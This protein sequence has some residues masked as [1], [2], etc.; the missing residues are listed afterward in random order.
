VWSFFWHPKVPGNYYRP[1]FLVWLRL[2][3]V[4][5]RTNPWGWHL[6]TVL[7]HLGAT[8]CVYRLARRVLGDWVAALFAGLI[9]GLHPI[10]IETTAW[11]SG[12]PEPLLVLLVIPAYLCYL[13]TR[14]DRPRSQPWLAASLALYALAMLMKE[15]ALVLP[16]LIFSSRWIGLEAGGLGGIKSWLRR[17]GVS[18]GSTAPYIVLTIPYLIARFFALKG[19]QNPLATLPVIT[20]VSTWPS[21]LWLYLRHLFWPAGL[22]PFYDLTY[23]DHPGFHNVMLPAIPVALAS[24]TLA[25]WATRS[26]RV[27]LASMWLVLPLLPVLNVQVFGN[28]QFA[29]DRYLY[30]PS[31]GFSMLVALALRRLPAG[32]ARLLGQPALQVALILV[33]ACALGL[34]TASQN[35]YY[36]NHTT[37][38]LH[39]SAEAPNNDAIKTNLA[40]LLSEGG[41]YEEAVRIY[42]QVIA[43]N[44]DAGF[45]NYDLGY[46]YYRM[47]KLEEAE[48]YLARATQLWPNWPTSF[49]YLGLTQFKMGHL[50]DAALNL[51]RALAITPYADN[52][53]F[54]LGLVLKMQGN[55]AGALAEFRAELAFNPEH[56]E[57]RQQVAEIENAL[58]PS[59]SP[60]SALPDSWRPTTSRA[61]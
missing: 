10:H 4:L 59:R 5:F 9:F 16:L 60:A 47:G 17:F 35:I 15:T 36:A 2:N 25:W 46:T 61:P 39:S 14:D 54:A 12:V 58:R 32:R 24:L 34:S 30:M 38:Y 43:R 53:H 37:F 31:V 23:V 48:Y 41:H 49:F 28:G 50:E 11:V 26:S 55:L 20:T 56:A 3:Y 21:L 42:E 8:L 1:L 29:H 51:R 19:L 44:P 13:R 18:L 6:T 27:A 33:L 52:Y 45:L 57:A 22:C 40:G 7:V